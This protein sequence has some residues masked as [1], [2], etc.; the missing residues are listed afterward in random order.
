MNTYVLNSGRNN[1]RQLI[2]M[3]ETEFSDPGWITTINLVKGFD[4]LGIFIRFSVISVTLNTVIERN[5]F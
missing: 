5:N 4:V 3:Q 1:K 2:L